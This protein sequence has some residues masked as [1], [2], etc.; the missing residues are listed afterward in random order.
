MII[1]VC[2]MREMENIKGLLK[3]PS[4]DW[5]GLIFYP[6]SPRYV[7]NA[8]LPPTFYADLDV[9]K[10]GV[11][12]NEDLH[13]IQRIVKDYGLDKVQLHGDEP[14]DLSRMLKETLGIEVIKVFRIGKE[15]MWEKAEPYVEH[16]DWL[17]FDTATPQF[18]GSGHRFDWGVIHTYPFAKPFLLSGGIG[19]EHKEAVLELARKLPKMKGID[20]NSKFEQAPGLKELE[21]VKS[22]IEYIRSSAKSE[23]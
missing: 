10:V 4:P 15:W 2:G 12:V 8:N 13:S 3:E 22:F 16:I 19:E 21:K 17:L 20:I 1:K 7:K 23:A 5:M 11:F 6:A 9:E 14:P 18:G